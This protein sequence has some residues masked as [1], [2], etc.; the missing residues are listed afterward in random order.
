[1]QRRGLPIAYVATVGNQAQTSLAEIGDALMADPRVTA[2]GLYVEGIGDLPAFEAMARRAAAA[3]K[4]VVALKVGRSAAARA[5]A[6]S[7]TASLAGGHVG[8]SALLARL[9]R[10]SRDDG[11]YDPATR[12]V[13][14]AAGRS[15]ANC[16]RQG[17]RPQGGARQSARLP[18]LYLGRHGGHPADLYGNDAG[19]AGLRPRRARFPARRTRRQPGL[20]KGHRCGRGHHGGD[21]QADGHPCLSAGESAGRGGRQDRRA[22]DRAAFRLRGCSDR[23]GCGGLPWQ[24]DTGGRASVAAESSGECKDSDGSGR[25]APFCR[26]QCSRARLG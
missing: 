12:A 4:P 13:V 2:L 20:G 18:H 15:A 23:A 10:G 22:R 19:R 1:M 5:G 7:H 17:A 24:H 16:S 6:V 21:R 14:P 3:G 9:R 8:A 26:M 25:Q 11:R